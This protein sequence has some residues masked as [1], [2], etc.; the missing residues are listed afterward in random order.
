MRIRVEPSIYVNHLAEYPRQLQS[1]LVP[2]DIFLRQVHQ[3]VNASASDVL[4][5][6]DALLRLLYLC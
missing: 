1:N 3:V 2:V 5:D 6:E 4:H